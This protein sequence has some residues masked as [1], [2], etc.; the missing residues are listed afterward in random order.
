VRGKRRLLAPQEVEAQR[1]VDKDT[2]G[3]DDVRR[4]ICTPCAKAPLIPLGRWYSKP[5]VRCA[6][7]GRKVIDGVI[8]IDLARLQAIRN[9]GNAARPR[10]RAARPVASPRG[11]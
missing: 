6:V 8:A 3:L 10:V 1:F 2:R 9:G 4:R 7:C 5:A 11:R